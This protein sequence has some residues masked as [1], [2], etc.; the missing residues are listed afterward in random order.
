MSLLEQ[1]PANTK[2][3][4]L[5]IS[6]DGKVMDKIEPR[7]L[8]LPQPKYLIVFFS[9]ERMLN[10]LEPAMKNILLEEWGF[11]NILVAMSAMMSKESLE[12]FV[13]EDTIMKWFSVKE[14]FGIITSA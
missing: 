7:E 4:Y 6:F 3:K 9:I 5:I 12:K 10:E 1:I 14:D 13:L 8:L 11:K 2:A